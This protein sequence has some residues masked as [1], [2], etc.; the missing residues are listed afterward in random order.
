MYLQAEKMV[1]LLIELPKGLWGCQNITSTR[2]FFKAFGRVTSGCFTNTN[3]AAGHV[4]FVLNVI[5]QYL[6]IT[7]VE[8][9]RIMPENEGQRV[10]PGQD[11]QSSRTDDDRW[12]AVRR[13]HT[14][15]SVR[16]G[17]MLE[18]TEFKSRQNKDTKHVL[19]S[20]IHVDDCNEKFRMCYPRSKK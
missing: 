4:T 11:V 13:A 3:E 10:S 7:Y 16:L 2:Y 18:H 12:M 6:R 5:I 17:W 14:N 9:H 15:D 20:I 8:T 19:R 1:V